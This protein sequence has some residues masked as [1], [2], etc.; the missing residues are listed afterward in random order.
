MLIASYRHTERGIQRARKR[1]MVLPFVQPVRKYNISP[2]ARLVPVVA[3]R[4]DAFMAK[5]QAEQTARWIEE[6]QKRYRARFDII[7]KRICRVFKVTENDL[8]SRRQ[9]MASVCA[10]QAICYWA[11]R[12]TPLSSPQIGKRLGGCDH[13]S[14]LTRVAAYQQKREKMGRHLRKLHKEGGR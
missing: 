5:V 11:R 8:H 12:L 10:R 3:E 4:F 9:N 13:S 14:V 1:A 7:E 6:R 2:D